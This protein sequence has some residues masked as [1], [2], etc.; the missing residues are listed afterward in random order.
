MTRPTYSR[1]HRRRRNHHRHDH[2]DTMMLRTRLFGTSAAV[3]RVLVLP[4]VYVVLLPV[5]FIVKTFVVEIVI[6]IDIIVVDASPGMVWYLRRRKY[7]RQFS[8]EL[9]D[10]VMHCLG[11]GRCRGRG[12]A[13]AEI[14]DWLTATA[15]TMGISWAA[16]LPPPPAAA[17]VASDEDKKSPLT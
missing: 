11:G 16:A 5:L 7:G 13:S 3:G 2:D 6:I 14:C 15:L 10:L 17:A 9:C 1:H 4:L 12:D 8:L